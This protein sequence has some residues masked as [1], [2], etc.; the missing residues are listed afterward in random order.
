MTQIR[1]W[2]GLVIALG[3]MAYLINAG[4]VLG[5]IEEKVSVNEERSSAIGRNFTGHIKESNEAFKQVAEALRLIDSRV[6]RIE[7]A[8][9]AENRGY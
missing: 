6:A 7:G 3:G 5:R 8:R 1:Q 4:M 9:E 2:I